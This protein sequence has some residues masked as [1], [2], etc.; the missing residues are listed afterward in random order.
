MSLWPS[1]GKDQ[2][3]YGDPVSSSTKDRTEGEI[4]IIAKEK[5]IRDQPFIYLF[6]FVYSCNMRWQIEVL[7]QNS[8]II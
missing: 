8:E 2:I 4:Y 6:V 5:R 1:P 3:V 7:S